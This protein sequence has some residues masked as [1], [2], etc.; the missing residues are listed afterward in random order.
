M[1]TAWDASFVNDLQ[2][3]DKIQLGSKHLTQWTILCAEEFRFE[4]QRKPNRVFEQR[5]ISQNKYQLLKFDVPWA[6]RTLRSKKHVPW[7]TW[8]WHWMGK[9]TAKMNSQ[10]SLGLPGT[11]GGECSQYLRQK[12]PGKAAAP[13]IRNCPPTSTVVWKRNLGTASQDIRSR[14]LKKMLRCVH[15]K[16]RQSNV[17]NTNL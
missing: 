14:Q 10:L 12:V 8:A 7:N 15:G 11:T 2:I 9:Q 1:D 16:T 4:S 6:V 5:Q 13:C 17:R 3:V